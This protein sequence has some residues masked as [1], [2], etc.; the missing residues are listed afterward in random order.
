MSA[1]RQKHSRKRS[2]HQAIC[3][4]AA[5][6]FYCAATKNS[7]VEQGKRNALSE[8]TRPH[9]PEAAAKAHLL[10][11]TRFPIIVFE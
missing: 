4:Q 3:P 2:I 11:S 10:N 5:G 1:S 7:M 9:M 6:R 8:E